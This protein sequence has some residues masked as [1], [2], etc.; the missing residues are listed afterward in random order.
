M[1]TT[2]DNYNFAKTVHCYRY[3]HGGGAIPSIDKSRMNELIKTSDHDRR[4]EGRLGTLGGG[5]ART[6]VRQVNWT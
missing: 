1:T 6:P 5:T 4:F 3:R 2:C